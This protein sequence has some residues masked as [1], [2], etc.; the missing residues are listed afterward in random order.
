MQDSP[1][2]GRAVKELFASRDLRTDLGETF[3]AVVHHIAEIRPDEI[4]STPDEVIIE[5]LVGEASADCPQLD[6]D[7]VHQLPVAE[8]SQDVGRYDDGS[9]ITRQLP[10]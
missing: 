3:R 2:G 9:A 5:G 6:I 8:F 1:H 10:R 4:L 7:R